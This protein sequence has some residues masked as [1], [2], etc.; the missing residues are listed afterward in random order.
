MSARADPA[1][2]PPPAPSEQAAAAAEPATSVASTQASPPQA[3][4]PPIDTA[5]SVPDSERATPAAPADVPVAP[6]AVAPTPVVA[7]PVVAAPVA[8]APVAADARKK[9]KLEWY[10]WQTVT[11]DVASLA[12]AVWEPNATGRRIA[13]AGYLAVP[14]VLHLAHS[15]YAQGLGDLGL[16]LLAPTTGALVGFLGGVAG[17]KGHMDCARLPTM[18]GGGV[19]IVAASVLDATL[20]AVKRAP[21][22]ADVAVRWRPVVLAGKSDARIGIAGTF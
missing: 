1:K 7:A 6:A 16:R 13:L 8:P 19:G 5:T 15:N 18:V 9:R 3:S 14:P 22:H 21:R 10:G 4:E 17:C 20:F 11:S 12:I 2:S